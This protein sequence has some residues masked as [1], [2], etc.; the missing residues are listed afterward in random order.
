MA[1][2]LRTE[3]FDCTQTA[4]F[5]TD[6]GE[7][8]RS[9]GPW[10]QHSSTA[11]IREFMTNITFITVSPS[12]EGCYAGNGTNC[13]MKDLKRFMVAKHLFIPLN[14]VEK[15]FNTCWESVLALLHL[16]TL[17]R[18]HTGCVASCC[19]ATH[20]LFVAS[21]R[22]FYATTQLLHPDQETTSSYVIYLCC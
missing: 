8:C 6:S 4:Q 21:T 20:S 17:W 15:L 16:C 3:W 9:Q 19:F 22:G 1:S 12:T 5:S 11:I 7:S 14:P 10:M 2:P 18:S 13:L